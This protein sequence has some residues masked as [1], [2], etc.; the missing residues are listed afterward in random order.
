MAQSF[1]A[2]A[3]VSL[4]W[5]AIAYSLSFRGDGALIG[6]FDRVF[7]AGM[8]VTSVSSSGSAGSASTAAR[9]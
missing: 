1:G 2:T 3:L 6:G 9:R 8:G 7:L 5:F 4:L